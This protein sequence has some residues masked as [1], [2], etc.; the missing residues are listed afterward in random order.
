MTNNE[1]LN[2]MNRFSVAQYF[3]RWFV[4]RGS[5]EIIEPK[6]IEAN[7][8]GKKV[9]VESTNPMYEVIR[10]YGEYSPFKS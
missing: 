5:D 2:Y 6:T 10:R 7:I 4:W 3:L 1:Q 8:S 9:K